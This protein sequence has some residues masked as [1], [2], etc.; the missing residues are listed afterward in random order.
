MTFYSKYS[1]FSELKH[2]KYLT[3]VGYTEVLLIFLERMV[4][5]MKSWLILL[6]DWFCTREFI[7]FLCERDNFFPSNEICEFHILKSIIW[8]CVRLFLLRFLNRLVFLNG[9]QCIRIIWDDLCYPSKS[10]KSISNWN[11]HLKLLHWEPHAWCGVDFYEELI[12]SP[13]AMS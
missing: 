1:L 7:P 12:R 3:F 6:S 5:L 9:F 11:I 8:W 13:L 2:R 10:I 4:E